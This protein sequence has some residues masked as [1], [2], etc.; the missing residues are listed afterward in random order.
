MENDGPGNFPQQHIFGTTMDDII[1]TAYADVDD[2]GDIDVISGEENSTLVLYKNNGDGTFKA[3]TVGPVV[4]DF[5]LSRG[6]AW[7]DYNNDG[8]LDLIVVNGGGQN[9]FLYANNG[10]GTFSQINTG[11]IVNQTS[12]FTVC[13]WLDV[14][15]DG[16]I[17]LFVGRSG[18]ANSL[19]INNGD[20]TF[21]PV[22]S[23]RFDAKDFN[24]QEFEVMD[25]NKDGN[26][27]IVLGG[28]FY[29]AKPVVGR[30][31]ASFGLFLSEYL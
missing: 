30:Y 5:G 12:A 21:D 31:D 6:G 4:N 20:L 9:N 27:D 18:G 13:S 26:L 22:F 24:F 8:F 15:N 28:N 16:D 19:Y 7:G 10:D 23:K 2:D 17:D 14:E 3:I 29:R 1:R 11:D 25:V